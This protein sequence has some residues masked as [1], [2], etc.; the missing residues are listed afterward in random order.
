MLCNED[1]RDLEK[2]VWEK[3]R[4]TKGG[5]GALPFKVSKK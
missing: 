2:R 1:L 5:K 3:Q 4:K